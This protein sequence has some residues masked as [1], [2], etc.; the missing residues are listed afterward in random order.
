M[1][2][3]GGLGCA[4]WGLLLLLLGCHLMLSC[5]GFCLHSAC[6]LLLLKPLLPLLLLLLPVLLLH[7][8]MFLLL[9]TTSPN[10]LPLNCGLML[11]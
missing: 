7:M 10:R 1:L 5:G 9:L 2:G 8:R 6:N 3:V 4:R 11:E